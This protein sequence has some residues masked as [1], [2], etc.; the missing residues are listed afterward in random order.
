MAPLESSK[1]DFC[2]H[3]D[4][5]WSC[6]RI[7]PCAVIY[8][9]ERFATL[10]EALDDAEQSGL[11]PGKSRLGQIVRVNDASNA[12]LRFKGPVKVAPVPV[13]DCRTFAHL[14]GS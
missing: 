13:L 5:R 11:V 1:G 8:S 14:A 4:G 12:S 7:E 9:T 10:D 3:L 6:H 2:E